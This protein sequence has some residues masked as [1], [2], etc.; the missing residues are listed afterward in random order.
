[1]Y[2]FKSDLS[3]NIDNMRISGTEPSS[4]ILSPNKVVSKIREKNSKLPATEVHIHNKR[5]IGKDF[6]LRCMTSF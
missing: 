3:N 5:A 4:V 6:S 2:H 1:M